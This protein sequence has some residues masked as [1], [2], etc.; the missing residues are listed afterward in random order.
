M[1]CN[2]CCVCL[3]V[4]IKPG[5][6]VWSDPQG[7][8]KCPADTLEHSIQSSSLLQGISKKSRIPSELVSHDDDAAL[9]QLAKSEN[10]RWPQSNV[11]NSAQLPITPQTSTQVIPQTSTQVLK[12]PYEEKHQS[13]SHPD[14][15]P[16]MTKT[17]LHMN[18]LSN[19]SEITNT[20]APL[21][22][23]SHATHLDQL[24]LL[25]TRVQHK[26]HGAMKEQLNLLAMTML[27]MLG[28][29]LMVAFSM[30]MRMDQRELHSDQKALPESRQSFM[31][32]VPRHSYPVAA[33]AQ[34]KSDFIHH[35]AGNSDLFC[36]DLVVP[37]G[38]ECVLMVPILPRTILDVLGDNQN[39]VFPVIDQGGS[40]CL[41]IR[42]QSFAV[43]GEGLRVATPGLRERIMLMAST[44]F[45]VLAYCERHGLSFHVH[46]H[47]DDLF[48]RLSKD[49]KGV[50]SLVGRSGPLLSYN[51]HISDCAVRV[52]NPEGRLLAYCEKGDLSH[53][54][55]RV[56]PL[57]D[58]GLVLC[59]LLALD[60]METERFSTRASM[61]SRPS[62]LAGRASAIGGRPSTDTQASTTP[63]RATLS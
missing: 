53:F 13:K 2:F 9:P 45:R 57:V 27:V 62:T 44:G 52:T 6:L 4:L 54:K 33:A 28:M 3:L 55:L 20:S 42:F 19:A 15:P 43:A 25:L 17:H 10:N 48:A 63:S 60:R 37:E 5:Y 21:S 18:M 56:G 8:D 59:G 24:V 35:T 46:R 29:V 47:D 32:E 36:P 1:Q 7:N 51:G 41:C 34:P 38:S 40:T 61:F 49:E 16:P 11:A 39:S 50:Y 58:V 31:N 12:K 30:V 26:V 14:L 22:P 23:Q